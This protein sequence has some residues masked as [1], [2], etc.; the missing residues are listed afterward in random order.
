ME[1]W[2]KEPILYN[3]FSDTK[4]FCLPVISAK[5][6]PREHK[7]P[8]HVWNT[9]ARSVWGCFLFIG[10]SFKGKKKEEKMVSKRTLL[11][12]HMS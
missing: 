11:L 2:K 3:I 1:A 7:Y 12:M 4:A 10:D 6:R 5:K 9:V 8:N